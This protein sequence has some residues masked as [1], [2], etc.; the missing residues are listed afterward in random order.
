MLDMG[1]YARTTCRV[2]VDDLD[3]DR[4]RE[5]PLPADVLHSV[6]LLSELETHSILFL[7]DLLVTPSHADAEVS[8]FL[9]MWNYEEY[10]HGLAL[11]AVLRAHDLD[12]RDG[13]ERLR[14]GWRSRLAPVR[15]SLLANAVGEDFVALHLTW[16]LVAERVSEAAYVSLA[17]RSGDPVLTEVLTRIAA[18]E[19]RQGDWCAAQARIRLAQSRSAQRVTRAVMRTSF[20][21]PGAGV[22]APADTRHLARHLFGD[23][24]GLATA[25]RI[26]AEVDALPGLAG[27]RVVERAR[28]KSLGWRSLR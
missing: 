27:L 26:D 23:A 20:S 3:L 13:E 5:H 1:T 21:A 7:R 24:A 25:R 2:R 22:L 8:A 11:D 16:C 9:T 14:A 6:H 12:P 10:G 15:R 28:V 17:A 19:R 18:Q 4:F